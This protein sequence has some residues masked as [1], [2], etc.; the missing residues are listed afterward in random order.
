MK[1]YSWYIY[2]DD[3]ADLGK[4]VSSAEFIDD[5]NEVCSPALL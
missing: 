1:F 4:S 2:S 5:V 3:E